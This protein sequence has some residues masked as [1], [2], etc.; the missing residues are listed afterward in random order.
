MGWEH[1]GGEWLSRGT[2]LRGLKK[3]RPGLPKRR[4]GWG[5]GT[6]PRKKVHLKFNYIYWRS[7]VSKTGCWIHWF[8]LLLTSTQWGWCYILLP[9]V[10]IFSSLNV[11]PKLTKE[12][13]FKPSLTSKLII[14]LPASSVDHALESALGSGSSLCGTLGGQPR[15]SDKQHVVGC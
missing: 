10:W 5:G 14:F 2:P 13:G 12:V 7:I 8:H 4:G 3:A 6:Q 11:F 9:H 1:R 15:E